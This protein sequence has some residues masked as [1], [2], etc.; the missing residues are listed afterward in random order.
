MISIKIG[1]YSNTHKLLLV[2]EGDFSF[3]TSIAR[4]FGSA[5][6]MVATSL[7]HKYFRSA[8]IM[9]RKGGEVHVTHRVDHPYNK[10]EL[11]TLGEEAGFTLIEKSLFDKYEYPGYQTFPIS[12]S[13]TFK[14]ICLDLDLL[15][16][17]NRLL[18]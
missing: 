11:T 7:F 18:K 8:K 1:H 15:S 9:L 5:S 12:T 2:G 13:F 3:S 10:W 14:F 6:N 16:L 4:A 17:N